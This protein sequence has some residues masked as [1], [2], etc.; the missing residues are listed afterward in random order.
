MIAQRGGFLTGPRGKTVPHQNLLAVRAGTLEFLKTW[1]LDLISYIII[2][3]V[4]SLS[5]PMRKRLETTIFFLCSKVMAQNESI[6]ISL[7]K[8]ETV[9]LIYD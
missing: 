7:G 6:N 1:D 2:T 4:D 9:S 8:C 5:Q 3:L